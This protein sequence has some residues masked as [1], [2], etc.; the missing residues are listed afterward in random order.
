MKLTL[1]IK[2]IAD[3]PPSPPKDLQATK[4]DGTTIYLQWTAPSYTD[5]IDKYIVKYKVS[6]TNEIPKE[7]SQ[8]S[9]LFNP[10]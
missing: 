3:V 9:I 2:F 7:V 1:Q 10:F 6:I 8:I 5:N 4:V